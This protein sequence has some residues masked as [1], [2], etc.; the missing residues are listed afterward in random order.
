M[1][2][3]LR[4]SRTFFVFPFQGL[5]Y[6]YRAL[7][8]SYHACIFVCSW[9]FH[10]SLLFAS[11]FSQRILNT[12]WARAHKP[13]THTMKTPIRTLHQINIYTYH[14]YT[15]TLLGLAAFEIYVFR[16]LFVW[17]LVVWSDDAMAFGLLRI[18]FRY[19]QTTTSSFPRCHFFLK[20]I[21]H[22]KR[23]AFQKQNT[24]S[25]NNQL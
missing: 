19:S 23:I 14:I 7:L 17:R 20:G 4:L 3:L 2:V 10:M 12:R 13:G 15:M 9:V 18:S 11:R 24:F 25:D 5:M 8:R 16:T 6:S 1:L 21:L 22:D